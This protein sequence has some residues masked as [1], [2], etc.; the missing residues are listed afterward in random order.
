MLRTSE[1]LSYKTCEQQWY[2]N[3]PERLKPR[4]DKPA[5]RFG[6]LYHRSL[7]RYYKPGRKRGPHPA[8]TFVRLY[9]KDL[10]EEMDRLRIKV[11]DDEWLDA[12]DLGKTMLERY[13][14]QFAEND[15]KYEVIASEQTFQVPIL[16]AEGK[17]LCYYV[18]TFD[19]IWKKIAN[20][21]RGSLWFKEHKTTGGS[22][23]DTI[24]SL[25][26]D[27]QAS[28]YWTFGPDWLIEQA[29]LKAK[30][31]LSGILYTF[32][33]KQVP[34]PDW[35]F[36]EY[37]RKLNQDGSISKSQ[38]GLYFKRLP[39]FRDE[40][41][42]ELQRLR[43]IEEATRMNF[44]RRHPERIT[45]NPGKLFMQNCR[46]CSFRDMC[47]LHEAGQDWESMMKGTMRKWD[48]Y[49]AHEI[50]AGDRV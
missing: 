41:D 31:K 16:N 8:K 10:E 48:P 43:V 39:V 22:I 35:N 25:A 21:H 17:V 37:G 24:M 15:S 45:K 50:L 47:E 13:V 40:A 4:E 38:P 11:A 18:G 23:S 32:S 46:F 14:E 30:Q 34:N 12:R 26:M 7:E 6:D 19:G 5:L 29:I 20:P 44:L 1:R 9:D 27:E 33:R 49:A 28:A 42:R 2:W 3:F 36:D